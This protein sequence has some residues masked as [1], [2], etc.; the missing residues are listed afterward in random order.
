MP[1]QEP[2]LSSSTGNKERKKATGKVQK[3][4]IADVRLRRIDKMLHLS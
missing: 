2:V 1:T 4:G 3:A